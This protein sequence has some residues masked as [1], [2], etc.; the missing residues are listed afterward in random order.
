MATGLVQADIDELTR[1]IGT[2]WRT[3]DRGG[4]NEVAEETAN[5]AQTISP[6]RLARW[7]IL[8]STAG[9]FCLPRFKPILCL[10][11]YAPDS[12]TR[13]RRLW[14]RAKLSVCAIAFALVSCG[15]SPPAPSGQGP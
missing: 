11:P 7:R 8:V 13:N 2:D 1:L 15:D 4:A 5:N 14:R 12:G 9:G 3:A 10:M 6:Q